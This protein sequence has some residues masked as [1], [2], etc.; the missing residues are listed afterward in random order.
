MKFS[1]SLKENYLFR[2]LYSK[3]KFKSSDLM[4]V[5]FKRNGTKQ[6]R[7][8][9]TVSTKIGNAVQR[10][11]VR[12]RLR[13]IYRLNEAKFKPGLDI[14]IVARVKSR[15]VSYKQLEKTFFYCCKKLELFS[16]DSK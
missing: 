6:N 9:I 16:G 4:T 10:N 12:R 1:T 13:E 7:L 3:G 11:K 15:F 2:R 14:I 5:Y 8:G